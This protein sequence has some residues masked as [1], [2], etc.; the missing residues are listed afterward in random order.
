M[1]K[2]VP[3]LKNFHRRDIMFKD[4]QTLRIT[5]DGIEH[6][7]LIDFGLSMNTNLLKLFYD[8]YCRNLII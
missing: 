6:K 3:A 7:L 8:K 2:T 1:Y 4:L 5:L